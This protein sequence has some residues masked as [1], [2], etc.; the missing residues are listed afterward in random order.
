FNFAFDVVDE[1]ALNTPDKVAMVWCDDKGE[2][3]VFTF[4]QMKK[5]S[6]KAAN[7]FISAG[8]GKGDPV[9]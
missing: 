5:Y 1:I 3:A 7:F 6:D 8:I 4:A 2:E 9:M